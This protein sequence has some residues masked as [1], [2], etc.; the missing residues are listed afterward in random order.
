MFLLGTK[1]AS[2]VKKYNKKPRKEETW[3]GNTWR[4]KTL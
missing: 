4:I 1:N 3:E 2:W